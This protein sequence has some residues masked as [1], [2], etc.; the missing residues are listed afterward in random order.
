VR[1]ACP[2]CG[3]TAA[4]QQLENTDHISAERFD[5][6]ICA[7]CGLGRTDPVPDDPAPYYSIRYFGRAGVRFNPAME[8]LVRLARGARAAAIARRRPPGDILDVGCGRA[9]MLGRLRER[10]WRPVGLE[11]SAEAVGQ[12]RKTPDLQVRI[13][14][15]L[16]KSGL[17]TA[18]F[19]VVTLYHVLEHMADPFATLAHVHKLLRRG[20]LLVVEVPNL[21]S[22]QAWLTRGRWFHL[23]T[24]RH[25]HHFGRRQLME[26]A[27]TAGF[28]VE[29]LA[30]HSFEYG[31]FGMLQSLL[32]LLTRRMNVL[33]DLLKNSSAAERRLDADTALTVLLTAPVAIFAIPLEAVAAAVGR[34]GVLRLY[35]VRT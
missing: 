20:G 11:A 25:L 33:Y 14:P 8:A 35:A 13:A 10:G 7:S 1:R 24:A 27:L 6:V 22:W 19:D 26:A 31:Y 28:R 23:D 21:D 9:I 32:N 18:S 5:V 2:A 3:S 12:A 16:D 4:A 15:E 30:T 17:H 29:S 34:G